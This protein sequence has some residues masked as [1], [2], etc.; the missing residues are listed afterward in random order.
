MD[1][2]NKEV[3]QTHTGTVFTGSSTITFIFRAVTGSQQ[4]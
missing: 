2:L 4:S 1:D 3:L